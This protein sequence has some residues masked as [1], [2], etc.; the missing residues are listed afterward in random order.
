VEHP[1]GLA[2]R[3]VFGTYE[4]WDLTSKNL[5]DWFE[6]RD[7]ALP[8]VR[9]YLDATEG[10]L[11]VLLTRAEGQPDR[12]YTGDELARW[13]ESAMSEARRSA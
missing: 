10:S 11:V 1:A 9:A 13:V 3:V 4:L 2:D 12:S 6:D 8:V 7:E 5:I